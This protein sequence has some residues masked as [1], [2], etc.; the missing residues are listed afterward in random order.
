MRKDPQTKLGLGCTFPTDDGGAAHLL[1]GEVRSLL[2]AAVPAL[3]QSHEAERSRT[4][5]S[6]LAA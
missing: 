3:R 6:G 1:R 4:V 2:A 5:V